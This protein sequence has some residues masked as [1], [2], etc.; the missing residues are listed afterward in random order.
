MRGAHST[1]D[2]LGIREFR[3]MKMQPSLE[4]ALHVGVY[5]NRDSRTRF[6]QQLGPIIR[7]QPTGLGGEIVPPVRETVGDIAFYRVK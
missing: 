6:M 1:F 3:E 7:A 5:D 2:E 4:R